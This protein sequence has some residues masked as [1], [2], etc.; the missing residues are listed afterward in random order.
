MQPHLVRAIAIIVGVLLALGLAAVS[1][2]EV[3]LTTSLPS[4]VSLAEA[5]VR[6]P[7]ERLFALRPD[8]SVKSSGGAM[9]LNEPVTWK[10]NRLGLRASREF[11]SYAPEGVTRVLVVGS[12][13]AF[14]YNV[15]EPESITGVMQA[16]L[17][18]S[19][20]VVNAATPGYRI[21]Q[22]AEATRLYARDLH[23][24]LIVYIGGAFDLEGSIDVYELAQKYLSGTHVQTRALYLTTSLLSDA[25]RGVA[26]GIRRRYDA[27]VAPMHAAE[28]M[29]DAASD[30]G[31]TFLVATANPDLPAAIRLAGNFRALETTLPVEFL[32]LSGASYRENAA[33]LELSVRN[34]TQARAAKKAAA[35]SA[36][37]VGDGASATATGQVGLPR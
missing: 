17:G 36:D 31:A 7:D 37:A 24:D 33:Q 16:K 12:E 8:V 11:D 14:G 4:F 9:P 32:A 26:A 3:W 15:E 29:L 27:T 22:I 25:E 28:L 23:P 1:A 21:V 20:E 19:F 5:M 35:A 34:L 13:H 2:T 6:V 30:A 18:A 10:T